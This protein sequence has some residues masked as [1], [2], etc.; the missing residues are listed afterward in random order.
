MQNNLDELY[1]VVQFA[2]PG[3]LGSLKEFK[4]LYGDPIAA[5]GLPQATRKAASKAAEAT[6]AL[7]ALLVPILLRR[8]QDAVQLDLP[9]RT[10]LVVGCE[11]TQAQRRQYDD[12]VAQLLQGLDQSASA[13]NSFSTTTTTSSSS[14]SPSPSSSSSSSSSL[15]RSTTC[16]AENEVSK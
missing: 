9:P 3:Y 7:R 16:S 11:L 14:S 5:G 6:A 15:S 13:S 8:T 12:L 1:A 10:D 4:A 2:V